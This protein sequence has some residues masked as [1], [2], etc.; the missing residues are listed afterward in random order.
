MFLFYSFSHKSRV[1]KPKTITKRP[2]ASTSLNNKLNFRRKKGLIGTTNTDKHSSPKEWSLSDFEIGKQL[3]KGKFGHVY[4][5]REKK[6]GFIVALKVLYKTELVQQN[7][8]NQLR[9]EIEIQ[10]E[11][12]DDRHPNILRL[13]GYFHDETRIFLIL[14][15]AVKGELYNKLQE[16][17]RFSE[18]IAAKYV[19]QMAHSLLYL[20][21]KR[22]IHRDIKPE[23]LMLGLHGE[24]KI[25][26]FGW[27][28]R[29]S[30]LTNRRSTLCG[31]LDYLPPEMVEQREHD[32]S[33]DRWCLGILLY[34]LLCGYPPF[35]DNRGK[36]HTYNRIVQVNF[37]IPNH[38]SPNAA[39]L[40]KKLLRYNQE[41]RL[42]LR[43][44]L[45]HPFIQLY[46]E[47]TK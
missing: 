21:S 14:E 22:I 41:E 7:V 27:S 25:G 18:P 46:K 30:P 32:E 24:L 28:V 43:E 15:L 19:A 26:D 38:I 3:G 39:D 17:K 6:S 33:V 31:T 37:T 11:L 29:Q 1:V 47:K 35:E 44:V 16:V 9:R 40:I 5:A 10:A 13:Y 12:N 45:S 36:N 4:L 20:H 34:E 42:S 2:T 23:N 8:E